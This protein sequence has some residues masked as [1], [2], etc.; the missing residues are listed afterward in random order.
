[1]PKAKTSK[2]DAAKAAPSYHIEGCDFMGV[3]AE[4]A[5]AVTAVANA[6]AESAK[7]VAAMAQALK[8]PD[9][10]LKIGGES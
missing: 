3:S 7:A 9:A 5:Q 6:M 4:H 1:M 2:P 10:L 8:G